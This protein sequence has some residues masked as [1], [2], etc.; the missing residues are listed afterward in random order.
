VNDKSP[1][2][3]FPHKEVSGQQIK[4]TPLRRDVLD[5]F[6]QAGKPLSAYEVLDQLKQRRD[7]AEPPTVYRVI[8]YLMQH[9]LVHKVSSANKFLACSAPEKELSKRDFHSVILICQQ[10]LTHKE[11]IDNKLAEAIGH[12]ANTEGFDVKSLVFEIKGLC[13]CCQPSVAKVLPQ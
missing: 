3:E 12:L 1:S 9:H 4:L 5:I 6:L 13:Q 10:C 8:D 2:Q 7:S 11:M